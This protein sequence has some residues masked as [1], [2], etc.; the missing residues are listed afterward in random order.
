MDR[1]LRGE[2]SKRAA[3]IG[4]GVLGVIAL[5][6]AVG[7]LQSV[8]VALAKEQMAGQVVGNAGALQGGAVRLLFVLLAGGAIIWAIAA[9]KLR[10][11][12]ATALLVS[13]VVA[14]LW[15]IDRLFF[16][17]NRPA[18]EIFADDAL[19]SRMKQ[20]APPSRV[21]DPGVYQGSVL[22][23]HDIQQVLGYHGNEI[24]YY[25]ELMGG[26]NIWK[27]LLEGNPNVWNLLA[28]N[29][30]VLPKEQPVAGLSRRSPARPRRAWAGGQGCCSSATRCCH[31]RAWLAPRPR[32]RRT[33]WCRRCST[34]ASR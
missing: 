29:H 28:M 22:M 16:D 2:V 12:L 30:I 18:R 25:D 6:G 9:G 15:S 32:Y 24:R 26:K 20:S 1:L 34:R 19:I 3:I 23:A 8:A 4:A 17:W 7:A 21:F 27:N 11:G 14:D 33:S 13:V 10:G 31:T 5:L